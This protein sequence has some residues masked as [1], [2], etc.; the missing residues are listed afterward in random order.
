[1]NNEAAQFLAAAVIEQA[2][3]DWRAARNANLIDMH[4]NSNKHNLV[5]LTRS[6]SFATFET[7]GEVETL[8]SFF[9]CHGVETWVAFAG[10]NINVDFKSSVLNLGY[11]IL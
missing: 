2:V 10:L 1:M 5:K 3:R 6:K 9:F 4:G 7:A 11:L 8:K